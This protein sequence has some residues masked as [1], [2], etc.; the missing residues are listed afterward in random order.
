M[1]SDR[2]MRVTEF[3]LLQSAK[4]MAL[5]GSKKPENILS[6]SSLFFQFQHLVDLCSNIL[7]I[8]YA[9]LVCCL[10]DCAKKCFFSTIFAERRLIL[11]H[12]RPG[13]TS[14]PTISLFFTKNPQFEQNCSKQGMNFKWPQSLK[15]YPCAITTSKS[16]AF[17]FLNVSN[18]HIIILNIIY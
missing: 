3:A 14:V 1:H 16:I 2:N 10:S 12:F 5:C 8:I 15:L 9:T 6:S 17:S 7:F 11:C 18:I 13:K 4:R